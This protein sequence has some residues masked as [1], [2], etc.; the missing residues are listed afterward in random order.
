LIFVLNIHTKITS[1]SITLDGLWTARRVKIDMASIV[2]VEKV[3]Y[4]TYLMNRPVYNLH[5]K[6]KIKFY[7]RGNDAVQLTDKE[8]QIYL[9]GTQKV[10]E[11]ARSINKAIGNS[12]E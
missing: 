7:T 10:N 1:T 3:P 6:G 8:G 9:I 2:S 12:H 5:R 4:S 11:M